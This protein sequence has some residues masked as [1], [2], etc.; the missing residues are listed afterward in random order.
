MEWFDSLGNKELLVLGTA[1]AMF[2]G[3]LFQLWQYHRAE[4]KYAAKNRLKN[5]AFLFVLSLLAVGSV[6]LIP[7]QPVIAG[8]E[9]L[10][11]YESEPYAVINHDEPFFTDEEKDRDVFEHYGELDYLGRCTAAEA[12]LGPELLPQTER[13]DISEIKP[14]GWQSVRY[15]DLIEDAFLYH[16]CHL[17]AYGLS[18]QNANA[19]NLITGTQYMN[20]EGMR[21]IE[22]MVASYI[23]RTGNHVLYR[24]T[25][26]FEGSDLVARGVL[27][28]AV[29][30]ED[31][32]DGI[33]L[34]RFCFNVQPGIRISYSD[35]SSRRE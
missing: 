22:G 24:V 25:P 3:C 33:M 34:N 29:S 9:T 16:R 14:S 20:M 6:F 21:P 17:I 12:M 11:V 19:G 30:I 26:Y 18:G 31:D 5:A 4:W 10:P 13:E 35:G 32:G 1:A 7:G 8:L 15:E 23:H 2:L 28:E 27:I